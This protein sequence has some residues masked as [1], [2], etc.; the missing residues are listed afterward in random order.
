MITICIILS[1]AIIHALH[2]AVGKFFMTQVTSSNW[3]TVTASQFPWETEALD[4]IRK[5]FPP[6]EPYR[7]W[8]NFEFIAD[9][10]SLNEVDLLVFSPVGFFL[11]EIKSNPGI[12]TGDQQTWIWKHEGRETVRDNPLLLANRKAKRLRSLL[13]KQSAFKDTKV[14]FIDALI[15]CSDPDLD[16]RLQDNARFHVCLRDRPAPA[17]RTGIMAAIK[18]RKCPGLA[19]QTSDIL[20]RP[21]A[22]SVA[23]ALEQIGIK[24]ARRDT[25]LGDYLLERLLEEGP[26]YQD[27]LGRHVAITN[28]FRRVRIYQSALRAN[29][30]ERATLQRAAQREF[31]ILQSL[32]HPGILRAMEFTVHDTGPAILFQY[33]PDS[34][35]LDH[36]LAER[37]GHITDELRLTLMRQIAET[38]QFAHKKHILHRA[39]NPSSILILKPNAASPK[40]LITNWQ[41]GCRQSNPAHTTL[42]ASISGTIHPELLTAQ[43]AQPFL[44]PETP[45]TWEN[46]SEQQDI[47]SLGAICYQLFTGQAPP[48]N[49]T[50]HNDIAANRGLRVSSIING[51]PESLDQLVQYSTD[52]DLNDRLDDAAEFL[53][54]LDKVEE[55]LTTPSNQLVSDPTHA[56]AGDILPGGYEVLRKLGTGSTATALLVRKD[57]QEFVLKIAIDN[58][59]N[60]RIKDEGE[61]L[62]KLSHNLFV[63]CHQILE[64]NHRSAILLDRAGEQTLAQRLRQDGRLNLD[65]LGRFGSDLLEA[66]V[67]LERE[68]I[69]HRD[70]KPDNIGVGPD[71]RDKTLHLILFDFSLARCSPDNIRAG[72]P[73]YLDP[74]LR[75]RKPARWDLHAER[76]SAAVTLYQMATGSLP[77]WSDGSDPALVAT[78]ATIESERFYAD[79]RERFTEFFSRALRRNAAERF[80]NAH[81]MLMQW[82]DL[83]HTT[84]HATVTTTTDAVAPDQSSL[85]VQATENTRIAELGLTPAARDA[86]DQL[87][88]VS[89]EDLLGFSPRR[90]ARMRGVGN[91]TRK[92]ILAATKILRERF[93]P[94]PAAPV[95]LTTDTLTE[96]SDIPHDQLGLDILIA[97]ILRAKAKSRNDT[98]NTA[99]N[100]LLGLDPRLSQVWPSQSEVAPLAGVTRGR[101]GQILSEAVARWSRD[102]ALTN[103]RDQVVTILEQAGNV[104]S[105]AELA[106]ALLAARGST[107]EQPQRSRCARAAVRAAAEIENS[108]NE[109]RFFP[110]R[111][112]DNAIIAADDIDLAHYAANLGRQADK[113]AQADPLVSPARALEL[114]R[115]VPVPPLSA[116]LSDNRL[117]RLAAAASNYAAVSSRQEIYPRQ[118]A[119][120]RALKLS[121]GALVGANSWTV[122]NIRQRVQSRYPLAKALPTRPELDELL[123]AA[124]LELTWKHDHPGGGAYISTA[125]TGLSITGISSTLPRYSTA[126]TASTSAPEFQPHYLPPDL[127]EAQKFEQRLRY[128]QQHGSFLALT[129]PLALYRTAHEEIA[130][131]FDIRAL[132]LEHLFLTALRRAATAIQADWNVVVQADAAAVNSPD[133]RKLNHLIATAVIPA[134]EQDL[135]APGKTIFA[136]NLNWLA[137]YG[138]VH[139]LARIAQAVQDGLLHG[140]WFLIPA[141][142]QTPMPLLDGHAVPVITS[143]QW[144]AIPESWCQNVHR[145]NALTP[146]APNGAAP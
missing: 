98:E 120:L 35:R 7:A 145:A 117:I 18:A 97:R 132:D 16:C 40:A 2:N 6:Y 131:R 55:E 15:F 49:L 128:A 95:P 115:A 31:Q 109:P 5:N 78:E 61:V 108:R 41:L 66:V 81:Q 80:D 33:T 111:V 51:A 47:F 110:L 84:T 123:T 90:L 32:D 26:G 8:A 126:R 79:L 75:L 77:T 39:L 71:K 105:V 59:H 28:T 89:V 70:I 58:D 93:K 112:E 25:R 137:R 91:K 92:E 74:F 85:L 125:R 69:A 53:A 122:E 94:T 1:L 14:P 104:M 3:N 124:G 62:Q 12:L 67:I 113:I 17:P 118:M 27:F 106:D 114:L 34:V 60:Q 130:R 136:W 76:F 63:R 140:A 86:L 4:Y 121:H 101:I 99:L 134:I 96:D 64:L 48:L 24:P 46:P 133:W 52:P 57:Q 37:K 103:L 10:G 102:P 20:N 19:L 82:N 44:A 23:R 83:F 11:I 141:S 107:L 22:K 146:T 135:V 21:T 142:P 88:I 30:D 54:F 56:K 9:D 42:T 38:I 72:T 139:F 138:Q 43:A 29:P 13:Q 129:V 68:G 144:A 100:A 87:N 143:N 73:G 116:P 36:L 119:P 45:I 50:A 65:L 127:A